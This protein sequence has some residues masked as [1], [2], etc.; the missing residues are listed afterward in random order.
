MATYVLT[1]NPE[2]WDW[3]GLPS[4]AKRVLAG[5]PV[6]DTWDCGRRTAPRPGDRFYLLRQGVHPKGIVGSGEILSFPQP[7][8]H[9]SGNGST[10]NYLDLQ[11]HHLL[12]PAAFEPLDISRL[13]APLHTL[14]RSRSSG[15]TAPAE[16]EALLESLWRQHLEILLVEPPGP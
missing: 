12:D 4:L 3:A 5:E 6:R 1:W 10:A 16:G 9:W 8:E 14:W 11:Y 13:H 2:K 7:G 15:A